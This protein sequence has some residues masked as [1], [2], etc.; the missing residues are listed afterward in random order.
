[1]AF[2]A[3]RARV[4]TTALTCAMMAAL[5]LGGCAG[6][7]DSLQ[8]GLL[9]TDTSKVA[10]NGALERTE[11][12]KA[13]EYWG[14]KYK[15]KPTELEPALNYAKDLKAMGERQQALA[16]IQ[17]AAVYHGQDRQLASEY[18]RLALELD[19]ISIAKQMLLVAD[20]PTSPDWRVI[21]ARG[22][23]LAKEG[24][25]KDAI[26]MYEK[27]LTLSHEQPS[28]LNNLAL[29]HAMSGDAARAE[30]ILRKLEAK[31]GSAKTRQNLALV[32]NLQGKFEE[33]R[34]IAA[35]DLGATGASQN[36][37]FMRRMVKVQQASDWSTSTRTGEGKPQ[38]RKVSADVADPLS[39]EANPVWT[40]AADPVSAAPVTE[41]GPGVLRGM[42]AR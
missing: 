36:D 26:P 27:A 24:K 17:Q 8:E 18:G 16:V 6:T 31:N 39:A 15:E 14:K 21:S 40:E 37:E 10:A 7:A 38:V 11:L 32:L 34:Q 12:E 5:L 2:Q 19:Q 30:E 41:A 28:V 9:K 35:K 1:M 3:Y 23:L 4:Q 25:Y 22:T 33:A 29:A 20:D 13:T 42:T